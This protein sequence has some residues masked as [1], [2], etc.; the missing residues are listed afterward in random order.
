MTEGEAKRGPF[1][2]PTIRALARVIE[3]FSEA[4]DR[5]FGVFRH[6][7]HPLTEKLQRNGRWLPWAGFVVALLLLL[8]RGWP[9]V[10]HAQLY[11]E[12][13]PEFFGNA[14]NLGWGTLF[15]AYRDYFHL[16][17]R[18]IAL[19]ATLFPLRDGP[20]VV[21][22]CAILI[23]AATAAFFLSDRLAKQIPS[24]WMRIF[25]ALLI[26]GYP[27]SSELFGNVAHSQ[28]FLGL[29]GLGL[30]YA[31]PAG[32]WLGKARDLAVLLAIALTGPFA[33]VLAVLAWFRVRAAGRFGIAMAVVLTLATAALPLAYL[34]SHRIVAAH[35][36]P[37]RPPMLFRMVANQILIGPFEGLSGIQARPFNPLLN[38]PDVTA[39]LVVAI[40]VLYG[41]VR[42]PGILRGGI[43]M[44]AVTV[45]AA[46]RTEQWRLLSAPGVGE[47]YFFVIGFTLVAVAAVLAWNGRWAATRW[48]GRLALLVCVVGIGRNWLY[49]PPYEK[50]D[51]EPQIARFGL[52][53]PGQYLDVLTPIDRKSDAHWVTSLRKR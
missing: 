51:F 4:A 44:G 14:Y 23:Q 45:A 35:G 18:L 26:V 29:L 9:L 21:C 38:T 43:F 25:W 19:I 36:L 42:G 46:L 52:L 6:R 50:F 7:V 2:I 1:D 24:V 12:D 10:T 20:L 27:N 41:L 16:I 33:P 15:R 53:Q 3:R 40:L 13:G 39:T 17:P 47:R 30:V 28:W 48:A 34:N 8:T 5:R 49:A 11:I 37:G 32:S 22:L 31:E